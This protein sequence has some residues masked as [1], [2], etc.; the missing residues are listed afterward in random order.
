MRFQIIISRQISFQNITNF[1]S[2]FFSLQETSELVSKQIQAIIPEQILVT[3]FAK[4]PSLP[5]AFS[6]VHTNNH[7]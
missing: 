2:A 6:V 7:H 4:I 3:E 5:S 1:I